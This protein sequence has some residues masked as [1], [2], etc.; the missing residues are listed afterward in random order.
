MDSLTTPEQKKAVEEYKLYAAKAS[1]ID[2]LSTTRE[3]TGVF[4]GSYAINPINGRKIPIWAADYVLASYGTGVVMAVPSHDERDF[5]FATKYGLPIERVVEKLREDQDDTLPFVE[6]DGKLVNSEG[7]N[8]LTVTEGKKAITE[9]LEKN[10]KGNFKTTYRLRDWLISRQRYWGAPIP[11][12]HCPKCGDVVVPEED[13]PVELPYDVDFT[14][15]GTS[16]LAKHEG[17]MNCKCPKCGGDA[18][19]D[20][21]TMDTFVCSS[22]YFL[23]Y[24]DNKDSEKAWD[25]EIINRML[26][27]DKYVGGAEH[28]CMHLL[29][30]RFFTKAFR[31]MG[32]LNF[33]EP[34]TSL[35]HQGTILGPDGEKMSKSRGNVVSPDEYISKY[36]SDAFRMYLGFGFA[37]IEGGPWNDGGIR[38]VSKYLDRVER[39][40]DKVYS[41]KDEND[42]S[43]DSKEDNHLLLPGQLHA[44][45]TRFFRCFQR[46]SGL[47]IAGSIVSPDKLDLRFHL[48]RQLQLLRHK[49]VDPS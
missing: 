19:R 27:V 36:G 6:Y 37:Y 34:F 44:G 30:A 31:D 47:G 2:R 40:V 48:F 17:F 24:P 21:D 28:A 8:G 43:K 45:Y 49:L 39:L 1:E 9:Y 3:K 4:T 14:P 10:G 38:S 29:Y 42:P 15:D 33:D 12:I 32:Y 46:L 25:P 41:G 18:K 11:I 13:L 22:W 16:P 23:R 5:E 26:P 7:F 20:P 35:V